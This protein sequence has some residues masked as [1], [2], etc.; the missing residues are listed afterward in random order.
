VVVRSA[1]TG[2]DPT[3][4]AGFSCASTSK[5]HAADKHDI[6][7][8]LFILTLGEPDLLLAFNGER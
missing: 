5:Y 4:Q 3:P 6:P 2:A 7:P 8:S 1:V